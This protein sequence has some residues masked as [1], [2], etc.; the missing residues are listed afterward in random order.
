[1]KIYQFKIEPKNECQVQGEFLRV[2]SPCPCGCSPHPFILISDGRIGITC[3]F[4]NR[5][6]LSAFKKQVRELTM[7]A[8]P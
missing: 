3:A 6:E 1:M 8:K 7:E 5:K 4:L 2:S